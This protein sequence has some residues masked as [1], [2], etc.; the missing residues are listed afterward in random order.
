MGDENDDSQN[1]P[2][3]TGWRTQEAHA[4]NGTMVMLD[5]VP[6]LAIRHFAPVRRG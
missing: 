5:C 3:V 4:L 1:R 6:F 2:P